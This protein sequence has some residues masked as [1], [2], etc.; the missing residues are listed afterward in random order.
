ME[1]QINNAN[2]DTQQAETDEISL[3]EILFRYLKYWKWFVVSVAVALAVV[4]VY[5]R[6]TVPSLIIRES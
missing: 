6:Y 1:Q 4:F 3:M 2:L 5:L